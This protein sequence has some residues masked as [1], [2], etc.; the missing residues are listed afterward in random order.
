VGTGRRKRLGK[1][2]K[3]SIDTEGIGKAPSNE[4]L[5]PGD[6]ACGRGGN[7]AGDGVCVGKRKKNDLKGQ[8]REGKA[9]P[10]CPGGRGK[11]TGQ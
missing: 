3:I 5:Y 9:T 7:P 11:K 1:E 8:K 6:L 2:R 10:G 4:R